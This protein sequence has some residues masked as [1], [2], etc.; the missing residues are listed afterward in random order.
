MKILYKTGAYDI[1]RAKDLQILDKEIQLSKKVEEECVF[2]LGIYDENLCQAL[3][4][5]K[6]IKI[7]EDRMKIM[8]QIR[9]V[10]FTFS[11]SSKD[12]KIIEASLKEAYE[13]YNEKKKKSEK[14]VITKKYKVGYAP[15]TYDL[16]HLGHLENLLEASKQSEFLIV[17]VKDDELVK[18]HKNKEPIISAE[19]RMEILRYF[20]M[21]SGVYRYYVRD[22]HVANDWIKSRYGAGADAI[23]L[24]SDLEKDFSHIKDINI[25]FT[26]RSP[27]LMKTRSSS[28]LRTLYLGNKQNK[29]Y[30]GADVRKRKKA[31]TEADKEKEIG[32]D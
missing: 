32:E 8:E 26:E 22:L 27:E 15:G 29:E 21:V 7:T 11:V 30:R 19:E 24:G 23:F 10:D 14:E 2:A 20:K 12:P 18:S 16:F 28:A 17:G 6:P 13:I 31:R 3:G 1:L 5:N 25:V 4:M 9:G